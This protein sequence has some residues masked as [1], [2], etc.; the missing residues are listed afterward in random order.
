MDSDEYVSGGWEVDA[1]V[2]WGNICIELSH[3]S[4][5]GV[6]A[7]VTA[8]PKEHALNFANAIIEKAELIL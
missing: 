3:V 6:E 2:E 4:E 8:M 5:N 1:D 7:F